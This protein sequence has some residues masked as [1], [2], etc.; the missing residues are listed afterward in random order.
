MN[1][2]ILLSVL[3]LTACSK[4]V[5]SDKSLHTIMETLALQV[6]Y[7]YVSIDKVPEINPY[8]SF[9][10]TYVYDFLSVSKHTNSLFFLVRRSN[11][12]KTNAELATDY[13]NNFNYAYIYALREEGQSEYIIKDLIEDNVGLKGLTLFYDSTKNIIPYLE[14]KASG[15]RIPID[16]FDFDKL[17]I[18]ILTSAI[19]STAWLFYYEGAWYE[20][21]SREI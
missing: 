9:G 10:A 12:N 15:E 3:V 18:P 8:G 21:V 17:S 11:T 2:I 4:A 20:Y 16:D 6:D 5:N 19:S 14:N 7:E 13:I 1:K